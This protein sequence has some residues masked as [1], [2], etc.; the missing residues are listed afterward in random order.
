MDLQRTKESSA[1][2]QRSS[3]GQQ[4]MFKAFP[5]AMAVERH[6]GASRVGIFGGGPA[7]RRTPSS[8][9]LSSVPLGD[10]TRHGEATMSEGGGSCATNLFFGRGGAPPT[11]SSYILPKKP[12]R[13]PLK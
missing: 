6:D 10:G 1:G 9:A 8:W 11:P 12:V 4:T 7:V 5:L 2:C 13:T 3:S